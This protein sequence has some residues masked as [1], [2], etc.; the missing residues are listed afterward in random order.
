MFCLQK[1]ISKI[2]NDVIFENDKLQLNTDKI[3][4]NMENGDIKLEMNDNLDKVKLFT[5]NEYFN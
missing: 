1:K 2:Y 3:L 5:K 4:I